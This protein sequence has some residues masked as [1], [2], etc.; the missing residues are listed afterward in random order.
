MGLTVRRT[1]GLR[2]KSALPAPSSCVILGRSRAFSAPCCPHS[3]D[4]SAARRRRTGTAQST[5]CLSSSAVSLLPDGR[6][7]RGCRRQD[8][9][10]AL[11]PFTGLRGPQRG[12]RT[13]G[14]SVLEGELAAGS[15]SSDGGRSH[16]PWSSAGGSFAVSFIVLL[17]WTPE[18]GRTRDLVLLQPQT[19]STCRAHPA[20]CK[21]LSVLSPRRLHSRASPPAP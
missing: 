14:P 2:V 12:R 16:T 1:D 18:Q 7:G 8:R 19:G 10:G 4:S 11:P 20:V 5:A 15:R 3:G 17:S 9:N 21:V 13:H 6:A